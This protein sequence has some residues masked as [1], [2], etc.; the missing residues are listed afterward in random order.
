MTYTLWLLC[1]ALLCT[2][3]GCLLMQRRK[4]RRPLLL[5]AVTL[6]MGAALGTVCAKLLYYFAQIDFMIANGWLQSLVNPDPTEWCFFGGAA[7]VV[8]GTWLTARL[9]HEKPMALLDALTPAGALMAALARFGFYLLQDLMIG[10]GDYVEDPALCFFPASVV[11]EW[12]EY[13]LAVFMFEG[14]FALIAACLSLGCF[15]EKRFLR[16][17]FYLCLPQVICESLHS[18]SVSWLFV[19]VEQVLSMLVIGI[20]FL[21]YILQMRPSCRLWLPITSWLGAV[22]VVVGAEFALDKSSWP[23]PLIYAVMLAALVFMAVAE[24]LTVRE[25]RNKQAA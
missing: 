14:L 4:L 25:L 10:L 2:A 13:Y 9:L 11:N 18:D 7:G 24:V 16:T 21:V 19:R 8:L 3:L 6:L 22:A 5:G 17:V 1:S 20:V 23:I 15:R 12:G